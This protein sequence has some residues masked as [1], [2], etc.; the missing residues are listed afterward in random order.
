MRVKK[1]AIWETD[2][3]SAKKGSSCLITRSPPTRGIR[4]ASYEDKVSR[5]QQWRE[6]SAGT[7]ARSAGSLRETSRATTAR[8]APASRRR[9]R[10]GGGSVHVGTVISARS[11]G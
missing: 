11:S 8:T 3:S 9:E 6:R 2:E 1:G 10:M 4:S 5:T 7:A